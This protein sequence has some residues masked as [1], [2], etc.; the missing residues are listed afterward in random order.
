MKQ[1]RGHQ[2]IQVIHGEKVPPELDLDVEV[3]GKDWYGLN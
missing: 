3:I 2:H 1:E